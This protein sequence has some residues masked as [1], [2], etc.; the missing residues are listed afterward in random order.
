MPGA[1]VSV[2][3]VCLNSGKLLEKAINSVLSQNYKNIEYI[4]IDGGSLDNTLNIIKK[5]ES[6]ISRWFSEKDKGV[7]DAMNK[8]INASTGD[9]LYFL[10]SDDYLE[11]ESTIEKAVDFL[12]QERDA[13]FI[14]GDIKYYDPL[15]NRI[16]RKRYPDFISR[17]YFLMNSIGHPATF[18]RSSCFKKAGFYNPDL[19]IAGDFEWF[20]RALYKIGLKAVHIRLTICVFRL[21]GF[22]SHASYAEKHL[23]EVR[24]AQKPYFNSLEIWLGC[25]LN[26]I[27]SGEVFRK[28][29]M[30]IIGQ[31]AYDFLKGIKNRLVT[32]PRKA[33]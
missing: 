28:I 9:I 8:G 10:N 23:K 20:L 31:K 5:Y 3:T 19:K 30:F 18:F 33:I 25:Y 2:V 11:N 24:D 16:W 29:A 14:Y 22:S 4:I 6:R 21:G 32:C 12:K 17:H 7:F 15:R 26:M 27:L 1:K 13:D